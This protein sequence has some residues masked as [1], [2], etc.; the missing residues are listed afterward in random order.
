MI[1]SLLPFSHVPIGLPV[2]QERRLGL[3]FGAKICS[4]TILVCIFQIK[5]LVPVYV[6]IVVFGHSLY[7]DKYVC[8]F[9]LLLR[10]NFPS[11]FLFFFSTSFL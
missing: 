4:H 10:T 7:N 5:F 1:Y 2:S 8:V 11:Y 9:Y 6:Q 3:N